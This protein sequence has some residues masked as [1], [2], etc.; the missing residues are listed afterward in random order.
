MAPAIIC[1]LKFLIKKIKIKEASKIDIYS[2]GVLLY[3]LAFYDYPYKLKDVDSKNYIQIL[4]NIELND[5]EFPKD[6]GHSKVFIDFLKY[7]LNKNLK[8]RFDIIQAMNHP[9]FKGYQI[10]LN[11]KEKLYNA[12]KFIIDLM[13]DKLNSPRYKDIH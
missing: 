1:P 10:I 9:W 8:E 7:C 13:M 2:F 6:T 4:K 11:E 12:E 5:L 3:L